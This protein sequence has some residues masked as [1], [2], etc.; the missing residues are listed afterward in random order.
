MIK[1]YFK[2]I[3]NINFEIKKC[4]PIN[5]NNFEIDKIISKKNKKNDKIEEKLVKYEIN[6]DEMNKYAYKSLDD[7]IK[8]NKDEN[9]DQF[10]INRIKYNVVSTYDE[11]LYT[12][13][14][15]KKKISKELNDYADK[16][17]SEVKNFNP[18][19]NNIHI[20][21]DRGITTNKEGEINE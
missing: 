19:E 5:K 21:E 15:D 17:S 10:E 1:I 4:S 16:I 6:E 14:L 9:W 20:L 13:K 2:D 8:E 3:F 7:E 11:N 12:T 18:N